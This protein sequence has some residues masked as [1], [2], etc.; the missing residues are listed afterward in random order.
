MVECEVDA[1]SPRLRARA[2]LRASLRCHAVAMT[3]IL[4]RV[5]DLLGMPKCKVTRGG[6]AEVRSG[7]NGCAPQGCWR[8][9]LGALPPGVGPRRPMTLP[10]PPSA[11]SRSRRLHRLRAGRPQ[12]S[13][14]GAARARPAPGPA[15]LDVLVAAG[16]LSCDGGAQC[17]AGASPPIVVIEPYPYGFGYAPWYPTW[18]RHRLGLAG[19]GFG[20]LGRAASAPVIRPHRPTGGAPSHHQAPPPSTKPVRPSVTRQGARTSRHDGARTH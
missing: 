1:S 6:E 8:L 2:R 3:A 9:P 13:L 5:M 10:H 16:G 17:R 12:P 11:A 14:P 19:R 15:D 4:C 7:E 20:W 18:R